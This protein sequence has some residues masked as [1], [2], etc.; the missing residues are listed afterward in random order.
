[1]NWWRCC[2]FHLYKNR[3][4]IILPRH[5]TNVWEHRPVDAAVIKQ[6]KWIKG[7]R[8]I[9]EPPWLPQHSLLQMPCPWLGMVHS[10]PVQGF[11]K[12]PGL[13]HWSKQAQGPLWKA[14]QHV[15]SGPQT[16]AHIIRREH[17]KT[18]EKL[19]PV[20][21]S[22][23]P[24]SSPMQRCHRVWRDSSWLAT[25]W[26]NVKDNNKKSENCCVL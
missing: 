20:G 17:T 19:Q 11:V 15:Q 6:R 14:P 3:Q 21:A 18:S 9:A 2:F 26:E 25:G 24:A 16:L 10:R 8:M 4:K 5:S 1:M 22:S 12:T 7:A 23:P 13:L